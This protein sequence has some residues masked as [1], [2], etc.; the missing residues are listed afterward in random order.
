MKSKLYIVSPS[1]FIINSFC[2]ISCF[3][4]FI[5]LQSTGLFSSIHC[6]LTPLQNFIWASSLSRHLLLGLPLSILRLVGSNSNFGDLWLQLVWYSADVSDPVLFKAGGFFIN[7][8]DVCFGAYCYVR[9]FSFTPKNC[10]PHLERELLTSHQRIDWILFDSVT[11]VFLFAIV[12]ELQFYNIFCHISAV[13][14][15][16]FIRMTFKSYYTGLT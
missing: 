16:S 7:V 4:R 3:S 12:C 5:R 1:I 10:A 8:N 2:F 11:L 15:M 6:D 13:C 9:T 14:V